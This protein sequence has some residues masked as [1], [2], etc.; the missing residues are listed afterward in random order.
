MRFFSQSG[1]DITPL[2]F[3]VMT[4]KKHTLRGKYPHKVCFMV[5]MI[6]L[7]TGQ[8]YLIC[9]KIALEFMRVKPFL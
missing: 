2:D 1:V 6:K 7:K 5:H 9:L 4:I 3:F 8:S